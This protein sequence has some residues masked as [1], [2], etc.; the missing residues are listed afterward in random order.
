MSEFDFWSL[1]WLL[2]Y[3]FLG[4]ATWGMAGWLAFKQRIVPA[5]M[6][7]IS[8]VLLMAVLFWR[9]LIQL[10]SSAAID[11]VQNQN[12]PIEVWFLAQSL[13]GNSLQAAAWLAL[14]VGALAGRRS[15]HDDEAWERRS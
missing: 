5:V 13:V 15:A 11:W 14:F 1:V 7:G 8:G 10:T 9:V 6:L 3:P 12:F 4:V 2:P